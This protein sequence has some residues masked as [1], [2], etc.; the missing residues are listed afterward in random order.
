MRLSAILSR[1]IILLCS[2]PWRRSLNNSTKILLYLDLRL[3]RAS[4]TDS[5]IEWTFDGSLDRCFFAYAIT[6]LSYSHEDKSGRFVLGY[7]KIPLGCGTL[8]TACQYLLHN[9]FDVK[10]TDMMLYEG[11]WSVSVISILGVAFGMCT[12]RDTHAFCVIVAGQY[13]F[14]L[15][16]SMLRPPVDPSE[17]AILLDSFSLGFAGEHAGYCIRFLHWSLSLE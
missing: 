10:H 3:V 2:F 15:S 12:S 7:T 9:Y 8:R 16:E 14:P 13:Q 17:A 5:S 1:S 6:P 4:R 11:T